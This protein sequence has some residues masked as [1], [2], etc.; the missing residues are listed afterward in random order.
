MT[1]CLSHRTRRML[2]GGVAQTALPQAVSRAVDVPLASCRVFPLTRL[3][4]HAL[5]PFIRP[6][7]GRR[8]SCDTGHPLIPPSWQKHM[9]HYNVYYMSQILTKTENID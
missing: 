5:R 3:P 6:G 7:P 2:L 1:R 9:L 8:S 4:T